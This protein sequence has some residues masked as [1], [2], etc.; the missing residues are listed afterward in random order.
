MCLV[1]VEKAPKP[2]ASC[3]FP[4]MPGMKVKTNTPVVKKAREGVMELMLINH[5][6]DCPICDQGGECDLQDQAMAFG[7]DRSRFNEMKRSTEDKN[8]GPLVKTVM[9]RCIHCTRCVRFANEVAGVPDL[10]VTGRGN[11]SE[12]GTYVEKLMGSELSGNVI[13]LCPVGALTAKPSAFTYRNWELKSTESVDVSDALGANI[14]I[15]SIGTEIKRVLPRVNEEV[16]EEWLSDKGRFMYD[17]L[18]TQR[19]TTPFVRGSQG[20]APAD[21]PTALQAAA[22]ILRDAAASSSGVRA[23]AGKLTDVET[24]VATKDLLARLCDSGDL[25]S[26][27]LPANLSADLRGAYT[28]ADGIWGLE[29]ADAVVL[30][31]TNPRTEAPVLNARLRR[32]STNGV[33]VAVVGPTMDLTYPTHNVGSNV[34]DIAKAKTAVGGADKKVMVLVGASVLRRSDRDAI[35]AQAATVGHVQILH[36][37]AGAV[38]ALDVGFVPDARAQEASSSSSSSSR[39]SVVLLIGSDDYD[40]AMVPPGAR[41]IYVG[42]HGER[43]AARAD[44]VLP[45]AAYTEKAATWVNTEGRAQKSRAAIALPGQARVDWEVVRALSEVAG[46]TLPYDNAHDMAARVAE[47]AP[48]LVRSGQRCPPLG[49][50]L[51]LALATSGRPSGQGEGPLVSSVTNFYQTDVVSRQSTTMARCVAAKQEMRVQPGHGAPRQ[52]TG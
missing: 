14:R 17:G 21:W 3:A 7:S 45:G 49:G 20:L 9:T 26:D 41:V 5:P 47:V 48:H 34:A 28:F 40:E 36:D 2:V 25:H 50:G 43:G 27:S 44:V 15:D 6:L 24:M 32:L 23:I 19:L 33:P 8:L 35:L 46:E 31:G 1:E 11:A 18:R 22:D 52:A 4:A 13:D 10:G 39:P 42:S 37:T 29:E 12:I 51:A 16:N 30:V 38:G